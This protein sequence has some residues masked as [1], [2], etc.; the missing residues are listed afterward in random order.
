[1]RLSRK[2]LA[3]RRALEISFEQNSAKVG[4]TSKAD[5]KEVKDLTFEPV[6]SGP[7]LDDGIDRGIE[8]AHPHMDANTR[9][10]C[11]GVKSINQFE[12]HTR[13]APIDR[14]QIDESPHRRPGMVAEPA[15][16]WNQRLAVNDHSE[17]VVGRFAH[18]DV[19]VELGQNFAH[20]VVVETGH[21]RSALHREEIRV[22][23][24]SR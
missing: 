14:S 11:G 21:L 4:M 3:K 16:E 6:G 2:V 19:E 8:L 20:D 7:E 10:M 23:P 12:P 13:L 9:I 1:M 22:G 24:T 5:T 15:H 18:L 17:F